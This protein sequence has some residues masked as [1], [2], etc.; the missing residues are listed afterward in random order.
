MSPRSL[1]RPLAALAAVVGLLALQT[2]CKKAIGDTSAGMTRDMILPTVMASGDIGVGCASG[3]ALGGLIDA[4]GPYSPKADRASVITALSA[5][6][7]LEDD[8]WEAELDRLRALHDGRIDAARDATTR[9]KRAHLVAARRYLGAFEALQRAFPVRAD[10]GET[11]PRFAGGKQGEFDRM[12]YL[13]GLSSGVLAVVHDGGADLAAGVSLS[14]PAEVVRQATCLDDDRWWGVP[15]ALQAAVWALQPEAPGAGDAWATFEASV[16]KGAAA[17]VRLASAFAAQTAATVGDRARLEAA[18]AE[19]AELR[20]A[21]PPDPDF[22][23]LDEYGTLLVQHESDKI[24]T[25]EEGHRTPFGELGTFPGAAEEAPPLD[26]SLF[27]DLD[28]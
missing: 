21:S 23:M 12:V 10:K 1:A 24:W 6:M 4:F 20:R 5:G 14:I 13:L 19:L 7:C 3:E 18:I 22:A 25:E 9:A 16:A 17:R 26:D 28:F 11:C 2:G 27:D 15:R 8:V